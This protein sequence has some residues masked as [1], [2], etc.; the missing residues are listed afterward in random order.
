MSTF[1]TLEDALEIVDQDVKKIKKIA[2]SNDTLDRNE[3][4]KL[5]DYIKT[6]ISVHKDE[7]EQLK[8]TNLLAKTDEELEALAMEAM[9]FLEDNEPEEEQEQDSVQ[10]TDSPQTDEP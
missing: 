2:E 9:K 1:K 5:T 4:N 7:R 8:S 10:P 6:L 3:A